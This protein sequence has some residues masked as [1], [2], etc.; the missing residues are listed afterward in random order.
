MIPRDY[1]TAWRTRAPWGQDSQVEQDLILSRAMIEIFSNSVLAEGLAMRGGAAIYKLYLRPPARYSEDIDLVQLDAGPAG[2]LMDTLR[3][4]LNSLLGT[5]RW[6]QT[7]GRVTFVYRFNSE[8]VPALPLRL[9]IEINSCEHFSV[10]ELARVRFAVESRWLQTSPRSSP[11][12]RA[13]RNQAPRA[14]PAHQGRDLFD[15]ATALEDERADPDANHRSVS[16]AHGPRTSPRDA[17]LV[18]AQYCPQ[19][20]GSAVRC[21]HRTV[22]L[23]RLSLGHRTRSTGCPGTSR[24]ASAGQTSARRGMSPPT[25]SWQA[26]AV[27]IRASGMHQIAHKVVF[28]IDMTTKSAALWVVDS[29]G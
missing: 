12:G 11:T 4:V 3:E 18:R 6:R 9:K 20:V 29:G 13:A 21:G 8:D 1:V 5:P 22:T 10:F 19:V 28:T 7:E 15:L 26:I 25:Q 2:P 16:T 14:L 23:A 24:C 27:A 17:R